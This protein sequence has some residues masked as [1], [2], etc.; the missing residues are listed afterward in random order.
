MWFLSWYRSSPAICINLSSNCSGRPFIP[1]L[2]E[3]PPVVREET[4]PFRMPISDKYKVKVSRLGHVTCTVCKVQLL[5]VHVHV[6][7]SSQ[8][9]GSVCVALFRHCIDAR[10][11]ARIDSDS[12]LAF[13][14]VAF[15]HLVTKNFGKLGVM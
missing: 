13:L 12:I 9:D 2:D 6:R 14:C 10:R 15:L 11:N 4:G 1:Y 5:C 3:L 8:C 7:P